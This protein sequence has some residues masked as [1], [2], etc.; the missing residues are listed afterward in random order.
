MEVGDVHEDESGGLGTGIGGF[1]R[2]SAGTRAKVRDGPVSGLVL[3][4]AFS[5]CLILDLL[6]PL[7]DFRPASL[8]NVGG[9]EVG[10]A[11]V[12][13]SVVVVTDEGASLP[14]QIAWQVVVFQQYAILHCL[15]PAFDLTLGLRMMW[16]TADVIHAL[17]L[18]V[19]G[20]A[21][22]DVR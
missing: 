21:G 3:R 9:C 11:L 13:T 2:L 12:V 6:S 10:Q 17:G 18:E 1:P 19:F 22:R 15:M 14:F 16:R 8:I 20:R 5:E 4:A 7:Q